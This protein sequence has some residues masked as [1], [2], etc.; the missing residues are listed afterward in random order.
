M[1][2][3]AK[4]KCT[5]NDT[6]LRQ[7]IT[8][9]NMIVSGLLSSSSLKIRRDGSTATE[10]VCHIA[11]L[12]V[13]QLLIRFA[14]QLDISYVNGSLEPFRLLDKAVLACQEHRICLQTLY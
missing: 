4:L 3:R 6:L 2:R 9:L 10:H 7:F 1:D 13:D 5:K 8:C 12:D 14:L 11:D